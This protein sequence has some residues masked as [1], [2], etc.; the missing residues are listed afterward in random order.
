MHITRLSALVASAALLM[1]GCGASASSNTSASAAQAPAGASAAAAPAP[2]GPNKYGIS[3]EHC[4]W[5]MNSLIPQINDA[6]TP[7]PPTAMLPSGFSAELG[8]MKNSLAGYS[9]DPVV[10]AKLSTVSEVLYQW[11]DVVQAVNQAGAP[12]N[13]VDQLALAASRM[14]SEVLPILTGYCSS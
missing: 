13:M 4:T 11:N 9:T 6:T 12:S 8:F 10:Q 2:A 1:T 14:S 7:Q 5:I 3:D